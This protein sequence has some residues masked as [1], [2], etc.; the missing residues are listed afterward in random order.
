MLFII[1]TM[2]TSTYECKWQ[3]KYKS[4]W[5]FENVKSEI[6]QPF[7]QIDAK[8]RFFEGSDK[9]T[10]TSARENSKENKKS[11]EKVRRRRENNGDTPSFYIGYMGGRFRSNIFKNPA[12]WFSNTSRSVDK[13]PE[14]H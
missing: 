3:T 10:V 11:E 9:P 7:D 5:I 1:F 6:F 12:R 8:M 13:W 2:N 14:R 4:G